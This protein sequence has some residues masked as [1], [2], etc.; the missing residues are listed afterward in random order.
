[1]ITRKVLVAVP[2]AAGKSIVRP[3]PDLH[4]A[5]AAFKQPARNQHLPTL[6]EEFL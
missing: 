5:D 1:M 2:V 4:E 3:A 6:M